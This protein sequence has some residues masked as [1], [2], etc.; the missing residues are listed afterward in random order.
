MYDSAVLVKVALICRGNQPVTKGKK[1]KSYLVGTSETT[2]VT[3]Y[4]KK[5]TRFNQWLAGLID[6]DG[7]FLV[8]KAGYSSL[9]GGRNN[10]CSCWWTF[11]T[12]YSE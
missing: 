1:Y 2:R 11:I 9:A 10:C 12:Y 7:C 6:G 4:G 5:E 3:T 8:S